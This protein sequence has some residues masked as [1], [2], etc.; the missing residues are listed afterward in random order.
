MS[1]SSIKYYPFGLNGLNWLKVN[2][3]K[4]YQSEELENGLIREIEC[5]NEEKWMKV[6]T[7]YEDESDW[8]E[9]N[10][11]KLI[12]HD[13]I[14]L[15]ENGDRWEGDS[16]DHYPFGFGSIYDYENQLIYCDFMFEGLKVCYGVE[17][18]GD[19]GLVK[20]KGGFYNGMRYGDGKLYNK[21]DELI[22]GGEWYMHNAINE[23]RRYSFWS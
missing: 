13:I 11:N 21:K 8:H 7:K 20:Y 12:K 23:R 22:Y 15:C 14:D 3:N 17:L 10:L 9:I 4:Y 19:V 2:G 16:L 6:R 5:D 1:E 18:Y